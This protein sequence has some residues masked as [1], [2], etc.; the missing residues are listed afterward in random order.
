VVLSLFKSGGS[1]ALVARL[2]VSGAS[3]TMTALAGALGLSVA[4][5]SR[6]VATAERD[7]LVSVT[8]VGT[9]KFVTANTSA[10][11]YAP[12]LELLEIVAGPAVVVGQEFAPVGGISD[13]FIVRPAAGEPTAVRGDVDVL[14][15]GDPDWVQSLDAAAAAGA[16][17]GRS[18]TALF[19]SPTAWASQAEPFHRALAARGMTR[20]QVPG[21]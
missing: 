10:P 12:L 5:V 6:I 11:F 18:V 21:A 16:R 8:K 9:S 13:L 17:L 15:L 3:E 20:V 19:A 2:Y 14:V 4:A 7:A 1:T